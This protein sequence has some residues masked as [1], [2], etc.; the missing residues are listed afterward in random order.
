MR[1]KRSR[2]HR[3]R[4][5]QP[6][7]KINPWAGRRWRMWAMMFLVALVCIGIVLYTQRDKLPFKLPF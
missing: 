4:G 5:Y 7:R 6:G 3:H 2:Q 1:W